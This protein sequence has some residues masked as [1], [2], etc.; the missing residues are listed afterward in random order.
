MQLSDLYFPSGIKTALRKSA[1]I[2]QH[3]DPSVNHISN[4]ALEKKKKKK[5]LN[6]TGG[7]EQ[8]WLS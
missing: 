5:Y 4:P 2:A 3:S 6:L 7:Y 1:R 8:P